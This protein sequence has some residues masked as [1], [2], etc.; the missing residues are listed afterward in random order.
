MSFLFFLLQIQPGVPNSLE[1][2]AATATCSRF[3]RADYSNP[4]TLQDKLHKLGSYSP[5]SQQNS[6]QQQQQ[7]GETLSPALHLTE[8]GIHQQQSG[9][10]QTIQ[11]G[12]FHIQHI[13]SSSGGPA[14]LTYVSEVRLRP[15]TVSSTSGYPFPSPPYSAHFNAN[16]K[17][18]FCNEGS[19]PVSTNSVAIANNY[20]GPTFSVTG[21]PPISVM[22]QPKPYP[23]QV[24]VPP[25]SQTVFTNFFPKPEPTSPGS[26]LH[27]V[28]SAPNW[29]STRHPTSGAPWSAPPLQSAQSAFTY[30]N[31]TTSFSPLSP[32]SPLSP[33]SVPGTSQPVP[34]YAT[35]VAP[36]TQQLS[37]VD[38]IRWPP[39][40]YFDPPTQPRRLRRVACTCPNCVNGVNSKTANPDGTPKKKQHICHYPGC[41]KVYGKTSHLRAHLRWHTGERPFVCN[42]L[43][44]GKRFTRSDELQRHL[45]THT[46]EKR[47]ICPECTKRFMRSDHL[48]KHIKTHQKTK[49]KQKDGTTPPLSPTS[50]E[51]RDIDTPSSLCSPLPDDTINNTEDFLNACSTQ[52]DLQA[53]ASIHNHHHLHPPPPPQ[54]ILSQPTMPPVE[55]PVIPAIGVPTGNKGMASPCI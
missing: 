46:G 5:S 45:R 47:F 13:P 35:S 32:I 28:P 40:S 19:N 52:G 36:D 49:D 8:I 18:I 24:V 29:W 17:S 21:N 20:P 9:G 10:P 12:S 55:T 41:G 7:S 37:H 4:N 25:T 3:H 34:L 14:A 38:N 23:E 2:L 15:S 11:N 22:E 26:C 48:S 27:T 1:L 53:T 16:F 42:W 30:A 6:V 43:F 39:L 33:M 50:S 44:C 54:I 51:S 31:G